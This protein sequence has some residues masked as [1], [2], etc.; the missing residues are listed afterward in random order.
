M[1]VIAMWMC[2]R[3][4]SM[5]DTKKA[6]D[7]HDKML[8]LAEAFTLLL[9]QQGKGINES[10]AEGFGLL[11]ARNKDQLI[12]ACKGNPE[13]LGELGSEDEGKVTRIKATAG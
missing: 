3:D 10:Q 1:A 11:L 12:Q 2:D 9:E 6:A 5:H 7:A 4:Q 13:V 8:E